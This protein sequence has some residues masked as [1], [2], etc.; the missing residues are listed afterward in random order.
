MGYESGMWQILAQNLIVTFLITS[1]LV[2]LPNAV[3]GKNRIAR[4]GRVIEEHP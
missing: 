2:C 1:S 3:F 4:K